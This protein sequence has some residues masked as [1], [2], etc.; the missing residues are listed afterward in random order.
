MLRTLQ[1]LTRDAN[2]L[3]AQG[4]IG[5]AISV[6]Q[7]AVR[8]FPASAVALHNLA[9]AYG[10][11][12]NY[13]DADRVA[14]MAMQAGL[15]A[16]ETLLVRARARFGMND[17]AGAEATYRA[18][19]ER[20]P[21]NGA[22]RMELAQMV[23]M[24]T[25]DGTAT[26]A[27][28]DP[29]AGVPVPVEVYLGFLK[30]QAL[31][32]MNAPAEALA[33]MRTLVARQGISPGLRAPILAYAAQLAGDGGD[34][35]AAVAFA[36]EAVQL[37]PSEDQGALEA[38]VRALLA[39]GAYEKAN[40]SAARLLAKNPQ[41]QRY[42]AF[43]ATA[44]R[45]VGDPRY[46]ALFDYSRF[47]KAAPISVPATWP[48][49]EAYLA[50]LVLE[51]KQAHPFKAQP[52]GHSVRLGSQKSDVLSVRTRAIA[53]FAEAISKP[54]SDY[55]E[56]LGT[57]PDIFRSRN[58]ESAQMIG[59]WSVWLRPGGHHADHV[60]PDGWISSACY[61]E[62]PSAV[63]AG[64]REGWL[65]FGKPGL[66]VGRD[67]PAEHWVKPQP[68]LLALFPSYMWHGTEMFSGTDPRLTIAFD[69][70]PS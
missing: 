68:G 55:M 67:L 18:I 40:A 70:V 39:A 52:F 2:T 10:D 24:R 26:L 65:R 60:H 35:Q 19:I 47:V 61:I 25:G 29:P 56:Q 34:V 43:Q 54:I 11:A 49:L 62:L 36:T 6:Y 32:F 37:A 8:A 58:R 44:W 12:R 4:R 69:L 31:E 64:G 51:L 20:Q 15:N 42:I 7:D 48:T 57:G 33:L 59:N 27:V 63:S 21:E 38:E 17:F 28:F 16:P 46:A 13:V 14:A 53:A 23:W 9:A 3:K 30:A 45:L 50:D 1:D 22:A 66:P 41:N 5:E